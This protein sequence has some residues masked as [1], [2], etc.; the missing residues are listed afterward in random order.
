[1]T[2]CVARQSETVL[3]IEAAIPGIVQ[4]HRENSFKSHTLPDFEVP[5]SGGHL[6]MRILTST[7]LHFEAGR[8]KTLSYILPNPT[9]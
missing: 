6:Y 3:Q 9:P 8:L 4:N 5:S 1:M 7:L 2:A